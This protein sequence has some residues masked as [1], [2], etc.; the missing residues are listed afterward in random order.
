METEGPHGQDAGLR[1]LGDHFI[2]LTV[3]A[4]GTDAIGAMK[5]PS[6]DI[7]LIL[8]GFQHGHPVKAE[9]NNHGYYPLKYKNR[10]VF[11]RKNLTN[12]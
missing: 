4:P 7:Y 1:R 9:K 3:I 12:I 2:N 8:N 11:L 10:S 6:Q 5:V